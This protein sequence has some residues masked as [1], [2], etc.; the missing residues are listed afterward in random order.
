[1]N[2]LPFHRVV[3]THAHLTGL[4][5]D[6][7]ICFGLIAILLVVITFVI[8]GGEKPVDDSSAVESPRSTEK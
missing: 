7:F 6:D 4:G 2:A 8:K 1:M 5:L 3:F